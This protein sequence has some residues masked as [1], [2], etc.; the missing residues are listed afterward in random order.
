MNRL[1][2]Q[3][4]S[5]IIHKRIYKRYNNGETKNIEQTVKEKNFSLKSISVIKNEI[6]IYYFRKNNNVKIAY[7]ERTCH[8]LTCRHTANRR[9]MKSKQKKA[10]VQKNALFTVLKLKFYTML[11]TYCLMKFS[12]VFYKALLRYVL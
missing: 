7:K 1:Y 11:G 3:K 5:K 6:I 4:T 12:N 8:R 9:R 2:V 10:S